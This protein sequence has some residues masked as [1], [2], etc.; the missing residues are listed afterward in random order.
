[1]DIRWVVLTGAGSSAYKLNILRMATK[2]RMH[3]LAVEDA[4][5]LQSESEQASGIR[6]YGHKIH[7]IAELIGQS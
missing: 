2:F 5:S 6:A 7:D 1:M 3:P 4:L